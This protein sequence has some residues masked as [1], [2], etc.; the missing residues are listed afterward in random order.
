[1]KL[2]W[3]PNF[4]A[5]DGGAGAAAV[6][7]EIKQEEV[8]QE[9]VKQGDPLPKTLEEAISE[10]G[11]LKSSLGEVPKW[12]STRIDQIT[13]QWRETERERDALR[14]QVEVLKAA[15]PSTQVGFTAEQVAEEAKKLTAAQAFADA[16]NKVL[17]E[18]RKAFPT[19][20][21]SLQQLHTISPTFVQTPSGAVPNM[22]TSFVEAVI[23]LE[24]PAEV[25]NALA[26]PANHD[27]AARIMAL[28]P[29]KQG[30]ALA[31]FA[32]TLVPVKEISK[33]PA[34]GSVEVSGARVRG[35]LTLYDT[36]KQSKEEWME[37]RNKEIRDRGNRRA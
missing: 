2:R 23:E 24:K 8:K 5:E 7:E 6:T 31:R 33:T 15:K 11:R 26:L 35:S 4:A 14:G 27:E 22:P 12:A 29:S 19:F 20:D 17:G 9:E 3:L 21:A 16:T 25:L 10:I 36:D 28:A 34:P 30:V 37:R 32:G 18:G 1:M 13:K